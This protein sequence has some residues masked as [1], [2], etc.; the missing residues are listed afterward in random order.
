MSRRLTVVADG[1]SALAE[2]ADAARECPAMSH[3][4]VLGDW[5]GA[6]RE[7]TAS[8]VLKPADAAAACARLGIELPAK[9]PR[10]ALD[11]DEL[12]MVWAMADS[13]GFIDFAD[14]RVVAGDGLREWQHADADNTVA[15]WTRCALESLSLTGATDEEPGMDCLAV[16]CALYTSEDTVGLA[17]LATSVA[18]FPSG[19]M[20]DEWC[21][22]CGEFHAEGPDVELVQDALLALAAFDVV[23]LDDDTA[24][25]APL[26]RWLTNYMFR[27]SAPPADADAA[28]LVEALA[29]LP[30]VVAALMARPWLAARTP[31]VAVDQLLTAA[32]AAASSARLTAL[33]LAEECGPAAAPTW[34]EWSGKPGFGAYA[35]AWLAGSDGGELSESDDAW[36]IVDALA[37]VLDALPGELPEPL[38]SMMLVKQVGDEVAEVLPVLTGSGHPAAG[39]LAALLTGTPGPTSDGLV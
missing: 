24:A 12:M 16:L 32:E 11:I 2:L 37:S 7:L 5:I 10:S 6:G 35:R 33:A 38:L 14:R 18:R 26:G 21:P 34:R 23:T 25:L 27:D 3:A 28:T 13:A 20:A 8:G 19:S 30:P 36:L 1:R 31:T 4:R 39:R 17:E 22:D 9:K 29:G 15:I